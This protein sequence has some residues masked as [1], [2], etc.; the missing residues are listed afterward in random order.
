MLNINILVLY[1]I[2]IPHTRIFRGLLTSV[3]LLLFALG[4][5]FYLVLLYFLFPLCL[6]FPLFLYVRGTAQI[7]VLGWV[8]AY[9]C[10]H[11]CMHSGDQSLTSHVLLCRLTSWLLREGPSLDTKLT[12]SVRLAGHQ[13]PRIYLPLPTGASVTDTH[14]HTQVCPF[15]EL[16]TPLA[17]IYLLM[18]SA[19]SQS[20]LYQCLT[21]SDNC[22]PE[23]EH[24]PGDGP[25]HMPGAEHPN[26]LPPSGNSGSFGGS[27]PLPESCASAARAQ[28]QHAVVTL[29]V[30]SRCGVTCSLK[31]QLLTSLPRWT[32]TQNWDPE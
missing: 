23:R 28:Q 2:I 8:Y 31:L 14:H 7:H 22:Q 25:L 13:V 6:P 20:L 18:T 15:Q 10:V 26:C 17:F 4:F 19:A 12:I 27:L 11:G 9:V 5:P 29:L 3:P 24:H 16:L 32:V 30:D 21:V 1:I